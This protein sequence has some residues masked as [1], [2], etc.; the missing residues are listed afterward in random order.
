VTETSA[1]LVGD[2]GDLGGA[3]TATVGFQ[4]RA[5][6]ADGWR[7]VGEQA[8]DSIGEFDAEVTGLESDTDYEFRAVA[9]APTELEGETLSFATSG[10]GAEPAS[11]P[12]VDRFDVTDES[13]AVW[14]RFDVDWT[15]SHDEGDLDTIV[16]E[17]RYDGATVAAETTSVTGETA[18][19]THVHRV[20][21]P[22]DEVTITI[23]DTENEV[24]TARQAV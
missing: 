2:L 8:I 20:R 11:K 23:T 3:S 16:T 5:A 19:Y 21:G 12:T 13:G 18:R 14:N 10:S 9:E 6:G 24:T 17:L 1:T 4:Q 15:V 22:V 7:T